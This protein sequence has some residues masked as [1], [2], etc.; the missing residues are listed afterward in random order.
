MHRVVSVFIL[1]SPFFSPFLTVY[2]HSGQ[3]SPLHKY[4]YMYMYHFKVVRKLF[5]FSGGE[6]HR[7]CIHIRTYT[8]MSIIICVHHCL[9]LDTHAHI[10]MFMAAGVVVDVDTFQ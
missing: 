2:A 7:L 5:P 6:G 1:C 3:R 8:C 9:S 4:V 10:C